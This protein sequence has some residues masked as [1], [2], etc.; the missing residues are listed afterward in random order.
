MSEKVTRIVYV[1]PALAGVT[2]SVNY[3]A[4]RQGVELQGPPRRRRVGFDTRTKAGH[5][6]RV[7]SDPRTMY[8]FASAAAA[9]ETCRANPAQYGDGLAHE[10]EAHVG[11]LRDIDG[12]VFVADS[13]VER[14]EANL[15]RIEMLSTDLA[16]VHRSPTEIPL[17]FQCNKRDLP[18]AQPFEDLEQQLN[19][20]RRGHVGTEA[21]TGVGVFDTIRALFGLLPFDPRQSRTRESPT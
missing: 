3:L 21:R 2:T 1:G 18:N 15:E 12:I 16:N 4:V 19:W 6:V 10:F 7:F 11:Y 13:Q 14:R 5:A 9:I 17:V 8:W 20:P